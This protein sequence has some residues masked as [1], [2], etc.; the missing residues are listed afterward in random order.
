MNLESRIKLKESVEDWADFKLRNCMPTDEDFKFVIDCIEQYRA[1]K[2]EAPLYC[3]PRGFALCVR[4]STLLKI[5]FLIVLKLLK[6]PETTE[7]LEKLLPEVKKDIDKEDIKEIVEFVSNEWPKYAPYLGKYTF[8]ENLGKET[9]TEASNLTNEDKMDLWYKGQRGFNYKAASDSKLED[10]YNIC[11]KKGYKVEADILLAEGKLRGLAWALKSIPQNTA[12]PANIN[13]IN[14]EIGDFYKSIFVRCAS[15]KTTPAN[16]ADTEAENLLNHLSKEVLNDKRLTDAEKAERM[17][18]IDFVCLIYF[19]CLKNKAAYDAVKFEIEYHYNLNSTQ[20]KEICKKALDDP[21][22]LNW[23]TYLL[24]LDLQESL[25]EDIEKHDELNPK[26]WEGTELKQEVKEKINFIVNEF[27]KNLQE[28]DLSIQI[29]DILLVGSN[30]SYNYTKDSDLDI[31][32]LANSDALKDCDQNIV[33]KLYSAYRTIFNKKFDIDFYG[34]PVEIFVETNESPRISNGVYSV[35]QE[36]WI[37]EPVLEDIPEFDKTAFEAA[38]KP[39]EDRYKEIKEKANKALTEA[40]KLTEDLEGAKA[41]IADQTR[42]EYEAIQNYNKAIVDLQ[43]IGDFDNV[44]KILSSISDEEKVHVGELQHAFETINDNINDKIDSGKKEAEEYTS[45]TDSTIEEALQN[46]DA[47]AAKRIQQI[48]DFYEDR[49]DDYYTQGRFSDKLAELEQQ[50]QEGAETK[51]TYLKDEIEQL[52]DEV[53]EQRKI[54]LATPAGE[55]STENLIFK[56]FRNKGYLDD[57]KD[58]RNKVISK[59]LCLESC[60]KLKESSVIKQEVELSPDEMLQWGWDNEGNHSIFFVKKLHTIDSAKGL[61]EVDFVKTYSTEATAKKAFNN[62]LFEL[63][64]SNNRQQIKESL[65]KLTQTNIILHES[66]LFDIYN[67][68][69]SEANSTIEKIRNIRFVEWVQKSV[70]NIDKNAPYF[71]NRPKITYN[72]CGK[73][74]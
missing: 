41:I 24:G 47:E 14:L 66:G 27:I 3:N 37:K 36:K 61:A 60:Q 64:E 35:M 46:S 72:I 73:I 18:K 23:I 38:F 67:L 58:L 8:V 20:I 13:L 30:C 22:I 6:M 31:H 28:D 44:I 4:G 71:G 25:Q 19:I 34:I 29:D 59:F 51:K 21:E 16:E 39:W 74:K 32:I 15:C 62:Y 2:E 9:L 17:R 5:K 26:L 7:Y 43:E 63:K 70:A 40:L 12:K 45:D 52:I 11:V 65:E 57:L 33:S 69:E 55:W 50:L 1:N 68:N 53:Y 42:G 54:G 49:E 48:I 10:C 56:E